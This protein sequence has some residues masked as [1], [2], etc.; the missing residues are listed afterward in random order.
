M[1]FNGKTTGTLMALAGFTSAAMLAALL[2]LTPKSHAYTSDASLTEALNYGDADF[3]LAKPRQCFNNVDVFYVYPTASNNPDGSMDLSLPEERAL[4]QGVFEAQASIFTGQAN[5]Y[6]PYYRQMSTQV[7]MADGMLA[8]D[9]DEFK[10]GAADVEDAFDYYINNLN[11]GRPFILA[12]HSQGTMALIELIKSRFGENPGLRDQLV[13]AYFIGY[14]VTDD[15]LA[16]AGLSAA[17][18]ANDVGTVITY[19]TQSET[20]V[21]GPMLLPGANCINPLNWQVDE[22]QATAQE[23]LGARFYDDATGTFLREVDNYAGA[24]IDLETGA[25]VA[26]IPEG[27]DL[28]IGSFPEGVYH[29]YDYAFW[30][31]NLQAN[32]STRIKAYSLNMARHFFF[33]QR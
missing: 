2:M 10:R 6:A 26:T 8:T 4:A 9:T 21:G 28:D 5:I 13:A 1:T 32:V 17:Q 20:S 27:E 24:R 31:R 23:N 33:W 15:D 12:G 3:W 14:T 25:L 18:R 30:Y 22:T 16:Q 19:N 11:K 7:E 29:R